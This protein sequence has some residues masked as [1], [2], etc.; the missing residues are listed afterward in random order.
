MSDLP[1]TI[2]I[3]LITTLQTLEPGHEYGDQGSEDLTP[4]D[5]RALL[6]RLIRLS[7]L[8]PAKVSEELVPGGKGS[9]SALKAEITRELGDDYSSARDAGASLAVSFVIGEGVAADA[10]RPPAPTTDPAYLSASLRLA[11]ARVGAV[12]PETNVIV[13]VLGSRQG[14]SLPPAA[15]PVPSQADGDGLATMSALLADLARAT[16][17]DAALRQTQQALCCP[18]GT[19][20]TVVDQRYE[21]FCARKGGFLTDCCS[22]DQEISH[23]ET[24]QLHSLLSTQSIA[25]GS[26]R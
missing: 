13:W 5:V 18:D 20:V 21:N 26:R 12:G 7:D 24:Y 25:G 9:A 3:T 19:P 1:Q 16:S 10:D 6:E 22:I 17:S 8:D 14:A 11:G 15:L 2:H 23:L 4:D